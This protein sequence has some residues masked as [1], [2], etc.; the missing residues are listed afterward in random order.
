MACERVIRSVSTPKGRRLGEK[1]ANTSQLLDAWLRRS[2]GASLGEPGRLVTERRLR[3]ITHP[4]DKADVAVIEGV[5]R[6][7]KPGGRCSDSLGPYQRRCK[8]LGAAVKRD[9]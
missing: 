1:P 5:M 2:P 9:R 4:Q 8:G 7:A 6:R 3:L